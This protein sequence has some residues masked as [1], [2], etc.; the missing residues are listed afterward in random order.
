MKQLITGKKAENRTNVLI[1][2]NF[3]IRVCEPLKDQKKTHLTSA[4]KLSN[5]LNDEELK[6][7]LFNKVLSSGKDK[8]LFKVRNRLTIN[9][10]SK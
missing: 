4:N 7:R 3:I 10:S 2:Q 1:N 8:Y 5:Y 9:F 6:I